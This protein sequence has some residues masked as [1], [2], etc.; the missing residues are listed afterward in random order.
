[1]EEVI[2]LQPQSKIEI[3]KYYIPG[4]YYVRAFGNT[5]TIFK[6]LIRL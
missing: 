4:I 2:N 1:M 3:G 5:K 6:K